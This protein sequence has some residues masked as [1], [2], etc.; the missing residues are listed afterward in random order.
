M[1]RH[2]DHDPFA[3]ALVAGFVASAAMQFGFG[4]ACAAV[5]LLAAHGRAHPA[6]ADVPVGWIVPLS[7]SGLLDLGRP[8]VYQAIGLYLVAGPLWA[9]VYSYTFHRWLSGPAWWRGL[10]FA[11]VPWL[12]SV[13]VLFPLTGG[14]LLGL[15]L[16]A[17][18]LPMIGSLALHALYGAILGVLSGPLADIRLRTGPPN[19]VE[20]MAIHSA[21]A[22]AAGGVVLGLLLGAALGLTLVSIRQLPSG[23]AYLGMH[24]LALLAATTAG[25]GVVGITLGSF[26]GLAGCDLY[27]QQLHHSQ[28]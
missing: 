23:P 8:T 4:L 20:M 9:V 12:F 5:A 14:G 15:G 3:R 13:V 28:G 21:E 26:L 11:A 2:A 24:P 1:H 18:P 19:T 27:A 16:G 17:G 22:G 7:R 6:W 25:G 10:L